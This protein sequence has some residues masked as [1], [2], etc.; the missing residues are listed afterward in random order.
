MVNDTALTYDS[1]WF[2]ATGRG[3]GD[4]NDDVHHSET[5]NA[6]AQYTFTGTGVQYLSERNGDMG[7][8]DVYLDNAFVA[9]VDLRVSGPRQSQVV[10][11]ERAGLARASH[12]MRI[13]NRSTSVGIVDALRITP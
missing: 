3:L 4:F 2:G 5:V 8:V 10:V 7:P 9:T 13:V 6:T 12:T 11:F 1:N